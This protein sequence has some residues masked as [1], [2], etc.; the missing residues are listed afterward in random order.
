MVKKK[1]DAA[2]SIILY[3]NPNKLFLG[4]SPVE[5]N[6]AKKIARCCAINRFLYICRLF[7][8]GKVF[9]ENRCNL[10]CVKIIAFV[11]EYRTCVKSER[12]ITK[13]I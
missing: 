11:G 13:T 9:F 3:S 12:F 1:N 2:K 10:F 8:V 4:K 6:L 5:K 7:Q